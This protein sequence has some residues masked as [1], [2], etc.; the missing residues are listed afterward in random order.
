MRPIDSRLCVPLLW[1]AGLIGLL[2]SSELVAAAE[3]NLASVTAIGAS[4]SAILEAEMFNARSG[5][6]GVAATVGISGIWP[7]QEALRKANPCNPNPRFVAFEEE[8]FAR[9]LKKSVQPEN[10]QWN[11][12][13]WL[14]VPQLR[15][16]SDWLVG[17]FKSQDRRIARIEFQQTSRTQFTL[18]IISNELFPNRKFDGEEIRDRL[19]E[20]LDIPKADLPHLEANLRYLTV[21]EDKTVITYGQVFDARNKDPLATDFSDPAEKPVDKANSP[22]VAPKP[23]IKGRSYIPLIPESKREWFSPMSLCVFKGRL[24]IY[25]YTIDWKSPDRPMRIDSVVENCR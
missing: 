10:G 24:V 9:V 19:G 18:T 23:E 3:N 2:V 21:G 14:A 15:W 22:R 8:W 5:A 25:V 12:K 20:L 17:H 16:N 1:L 13:E 11:S 4:E 6:P 7:Q